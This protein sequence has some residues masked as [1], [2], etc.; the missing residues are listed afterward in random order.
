M[1]CKE[2]LFWAFLT[3]ELHFTAI[4]NEQ[5]AA[6]VI[7]TQCGVASRSEFADNPRAR[8]IWFGIDRQYQAWKARENGF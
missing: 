5:R 1:R 7:R 2:P 8:E 4:T 6:E 3:E